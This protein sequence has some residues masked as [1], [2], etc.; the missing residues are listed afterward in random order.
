MLSQFARAN[1]LAVRLGR[2]PAKRLQPAAL[3]PIINNVTITL[4][5]LLPT[6]DLADLDE[7]Y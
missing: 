5:N 1:P 4:W 6:R 2:A 3:E 7:V